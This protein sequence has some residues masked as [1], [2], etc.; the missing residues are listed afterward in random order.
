MKGDTAL[1]CPSPTNTEGLPTSSKHNSLKCEC[2]YEYYS[3]NTTQLFVS[4][5][6]GLPNMSDNVFSSLR[7][8]A[9]TLVFSAWLW[10]WSG[11]EKGFASFSAHISQIR[12]YVAM[13]FS[14]LTA[15]GTPVSLPVLIDD[16]FLKTDLFFL[17]QD[18]EVMDFTRAVL[19][20]MIL[21]SF[22]ETMGQPIICMMD[23]R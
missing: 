23:G 21:D 22:T 7:M 20:H 14:T 4:T 18:S 3:I 9:N 11:R 2:R 19:V 1:L 8:S 15:V 5:H 6:V 12:Q 17:E 16:C 10:G 13:I